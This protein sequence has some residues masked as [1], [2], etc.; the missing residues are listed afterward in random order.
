MRQRGCLHAECLQSTCTSPSTFT[1][2]RGE[3]RSRLPPPAQRSAPRRPTRP[4]WPPAPPTAP[5]WCPCRDHDRWHHPAKKKKMS[6]ANSG[7]TTHGDEVH[8]QGSREVRDDSARQFQHPTQEPSAHRRAQQSI[9]G[10][11]VPRTHSAHA[12]TRVTYPRPRQVHPVLLPR[13][14]KRVR[15]RG[16]NLLVRLKLFPHVL[17]R[18]SKKKAGSNHDTKEE[19]GGQTT[20]SVSGAAG[21][22]R[23]PSSPTTSV[24]RALGCEK[25]KKRHR[26]RPGYTAARARAYTVAE[27]ALRGGQHRPVD[28]QQRAV[29][30]QH[31]P[32]AGPE[33]TGGSSRCRRC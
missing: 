8:E 6:H 21:N 23:P 19:A 11:L 28:A 16:R 32:A 5:P 1:C 20:S 13:L 27:G 22:V 10:Q 2:H 30:A 4:A 17:Q 9:S 3:H 26:E 15:L 12:L 7:K 14:H 25:N 18:Q 31:L 24:A 33:N 29:Q